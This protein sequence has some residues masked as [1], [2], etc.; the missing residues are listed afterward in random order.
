MKTKL[1]VGQSSLRGTLG[2]YKS[3]FNLLELRA[4]PGRVPRRGLL[5]RWSEEAGEDFAFSVMLSR[6]VGQLDK[7]CAAAIQLGQDAADAL[8]ARWIVVQT[9]PTVGP[10]QRSR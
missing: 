5:Q 3:R 9:D 10:S 6:H 2:K 7:D 4:E 8:N 1:Y